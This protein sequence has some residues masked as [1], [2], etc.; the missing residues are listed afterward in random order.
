[1]NQLTYQV[2][3]THRDELLREAAE[4]RL[5]SQAVSRQR[6]APKKP[7]TPHAFPDWHFL[8]ASIVRLG[9]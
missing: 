6:K 3:L 9:R 8:R 2:A 4:R 5:T 7:L 1:M